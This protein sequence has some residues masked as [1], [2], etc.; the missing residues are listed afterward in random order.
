MGR[1]PAA[2]SNNAHLQQPLD[3]DLWCGSPAKC[4][5]LWTT[6]KVRYVNKSLC[7]NDL[8]SRTYKPNSVRPAAGRPF[9]WAAHH[10]A[11][12]ATYPEVFESTPRLKSL[13]GAPPAR[14]ASTRP[15]KAGTS[16]L[17]GLAPCGVCR[18]RDIAVA[19]VRSYRT[20]SPLPRDGGAVFFL[21]HF[22]STSLDA[23][24]PDVI[25]HTALWSSDF[26]PSPNPMERWKSIMLVI[27]P[28]WF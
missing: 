13:S 8:G 14:R 15:A 10:C 26:P 21:W 20:F 28:R 27:G 6:G 5:L 18:A 22:P 2:M 3:D 4:P 1:H 23:G 25:R 16:S 24:F 9:L 7:S 17:F 11:A 12:Q 19:A